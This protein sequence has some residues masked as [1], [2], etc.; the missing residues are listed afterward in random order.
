LYYGAS[1]SS[2]YR[3]CAALHQAD[4]LDVAELTTLAEVLAAYAKEVQAQED[5]AWKIINTRQQH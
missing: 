1:I 2:D 3:N 4:R 5:A